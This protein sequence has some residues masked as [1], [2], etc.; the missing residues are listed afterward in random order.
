MADKCR[1]CFEQHCFS[2]DGKVTEETRPLK[3]KLDE[4]DEIFVMAKVSHSSIISLK[5]KTSDSEL[6]TLAPTP[7]PKHTHTRIEY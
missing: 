6:P 2:A 4:E 5:K 7:S 1:I 3:P